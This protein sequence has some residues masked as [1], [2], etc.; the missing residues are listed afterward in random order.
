MQ[1]VEQLQAHALVRFAEVYL[2]ASPR[3]R[4]AAFTA[5][6][7]YT[8]ALDETVD[9]GLVESVYGDSLPRL[10]LAPVGD[11]AAKLLQHIDDR[12]V[13]LD[14]EPIDNNPRARL[15]TPAQR[16]ALAW[17][18]K[19]CVHPGCNRP[20]TF[21]LHAHHTISYSQGGPTTLDNLVLLCAEHHDQA[22]HAGL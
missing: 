9:A 3:Q 21:S 19:H 11:S 7:L 18:D 20:A 22:H 2:E 5:P 15:A 16:I 4:V 1:S 14:G 13:L 12:P 17:R 10:V 8:A 6:T